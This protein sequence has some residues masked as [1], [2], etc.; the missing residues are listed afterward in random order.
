MSYARHL[1]LLSPNVTKFR[2]GILRLKSTLRE[3]FLCSKRLFIKAEKKTN[4]HLKLHT[5]GPR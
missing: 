4:A 1:M 5:V 2:L 3:L